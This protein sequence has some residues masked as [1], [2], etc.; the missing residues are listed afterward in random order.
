MFCRASTLTATFTASMMKPNP[1]A[2]TS[3]RRLASMFTALFYTDA[4]VEESRWSCHGMASSSTR[5]VG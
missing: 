1:L 3:A 2:S 5:H 4:S